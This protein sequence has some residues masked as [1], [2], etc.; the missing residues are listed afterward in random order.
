MTQNDCEKTIEL[1][2]FEQDGKSPTL[3]TYKTFSRLFRSHTTSRTNGV[4]HIY[5]AH[6]TKQELFE[7]HISYCSANETVAV[8][9]PARN[10]ILKF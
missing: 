4:T 7:K 10:T 9:M 6:F 2:L 3:H 1:F 5:K 8:K